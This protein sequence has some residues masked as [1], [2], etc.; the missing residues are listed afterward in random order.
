V[1]KSLNYFFPL[2]RLSFLY[3]KLLLPS[4]KATCK[5]HV[6][7]KSKIY[8]FPPGKAKFQVLKSLKITSSTLHIP[9]NTKFHLLKITYPP[10][11]A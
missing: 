6:L 3:Y 2:G 10:R 7:K 11:K 4:G 5:F 9:L 8:F 1:L